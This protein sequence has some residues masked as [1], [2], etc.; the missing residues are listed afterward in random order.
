[1]C[2]TLLAAGA[3]CLHFYTLNLEKSVT[4]ILQGLN[5][6]EEEIRKPLP[7]MPVSHNS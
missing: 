6:I 2:Q 3:P 7:W 1:M 5:L 4:Q